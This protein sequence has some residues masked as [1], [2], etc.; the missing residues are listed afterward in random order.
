MVEEQR[1]G[2][3]LGVTAE[4]S[5]PCGAAAQGIRLAGSEQDVGEPWVALELQTVA[6][7]W[8]VAEKMGNQASG[9]GY[10]RRG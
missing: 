3:E 1:H 8:P 10:Q 7:H 2:E 9:E 5:V 6:T 4:A